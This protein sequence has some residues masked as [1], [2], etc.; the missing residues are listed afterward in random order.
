MEM[1]ELFLPEGTV[2]GSDLGTWTSISIKKFNKI[3][4]KFRHLS[5][6]GEQLSI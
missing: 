6:L 4:G 3:L 5:Y 2:S 1:F